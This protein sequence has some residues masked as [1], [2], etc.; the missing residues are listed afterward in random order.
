[1]MNENTSDD[2]TPDPEN[3]KVD[4]SANKKPQTPADYAKQRGG[5]LVNE[6]SQAGQGVGKSGGG[7]QRYVKAG[8]QLIRE[9]NKLPK[10]DPRRAAMKKEGNRL[11]KQGNSINHK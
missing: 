9:A 5:E 3:N 1:M 4:T 10:N 7:G 6:N 2:A 11:I 8:T